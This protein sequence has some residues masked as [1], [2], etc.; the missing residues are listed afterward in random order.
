[1]QESEAEAAFYP[2]ARAGG[3][4]KEDG[5]GGEVVSFEVELQC[6]DGRSSG[7]KSV[8]LVPAR[9]WISG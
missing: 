6:G 9:G 5:V 8:G 2:A 7:G 3:K 1:M 4:G